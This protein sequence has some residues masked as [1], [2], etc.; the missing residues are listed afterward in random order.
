M[1]YPDSKDHPAAPRGAFTVAELLISFSIV[2]AI[3]LGG[4]LVHLKVRQIALE[5]RA[6]HWATHVGS[7]LRFFSHD[8]GGACPDVAHN[9]SHALLRQRINRDAPPAEKAQDN[10]TDNFSA[11]IGGGYI[12]MEAAYYLDGECYATGRRCPPPDHDIS[13]PIRPETIAWAYVRGLRSDT[14]HPETPLVMTR[15]ERSGTGLRWP[16]KPGRVGG[17]LSGKIVVAFMDGST[18]LI[19]LSE[20]GAARDLQGRDITS[21]AQASPYAHGQKTKI[22]QP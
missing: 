14:A 8:H 6:T 21:P 10:A 22:I 9:P 3:L 19:A 2:A 18:R 4:F 7:G 1:N 12:M 20:N 11:V 5:A 15:N 17:V 13:T 16:R